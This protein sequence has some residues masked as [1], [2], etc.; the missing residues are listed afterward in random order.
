MK[1]SVRFM[2]AQIDGGTRLGQA[3]AHPQRKRRSL[4]RQI[5]R[6][7]P[8]P[9]GVASA[10]WMQLTPFQRQVYQAVSRIPKGQ[11]R[12]YQWVATRIGRPQAARAI[13]NALQRNP[14]AP[15]VPC[16]RV[17]RSDG[18]LGGFAN[19]PEAKRRLLQTERLAA[20]PTTSAAQNR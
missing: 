7:P 3:T 12:S 2:N 20:H 6:A 16:H 15:V 18:S 1:G 4:T 10:S 19:G 13:G 5:R 14:Y 9:A 11:T 8:P 17:I